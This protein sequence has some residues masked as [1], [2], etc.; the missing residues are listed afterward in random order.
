MNDGH[1]VEVEVFGGKIV[2]RIASQTIENKIVIVTKEEWDKS[3]TEG[4]TPIGVGFDENK[5]FPC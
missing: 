2:R 5:V 1:A 4:R 3:I